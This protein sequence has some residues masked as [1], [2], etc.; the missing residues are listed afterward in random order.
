M[1]TLM[2]R[3]FGIDFFEHLEMMAASNKNW[4]RC[5][6]RH[7]NIKTVKLDHNNPEFC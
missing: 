1:G 6:R 2:Q 7:C 3:L 5:T 4:L